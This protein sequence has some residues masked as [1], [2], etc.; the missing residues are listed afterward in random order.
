MSFRQPGEADNPLSSEEDRRHQEGMASMRAAVAGGKTFAEAAAAL[1]G[2]A[3][4]MQ[5]LI[6]DDFLKIFI[7]EEHFG[8]GRTLGEVALALALSYEKV[9]AAREAMLEEV[10]REMARQYRQEIDRQAH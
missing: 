2:L 9:A 4:G 10:G 3:V 8:Q 5:A 7:A 6:A 1:S